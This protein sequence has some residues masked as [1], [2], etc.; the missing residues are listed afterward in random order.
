MRSPYDRYR[1]DGD[2]TAISE[3]AKRGERIFFSDKRGSCAQCHGGWNFSGSL[4]FAGDTSARAAFFNTGL[5]NV[6]GRYSYP[7]PNTG[8][9][10]VSGRLADVGKFRPPTLRNIAVTAPYM[11]DGS[12]STLEDVIDHYAAGGRTI[13]DGPFAG[14]GRDNR[15]K[16]PHVHGFA[17]TSSERRDLIAFLETLTDTAFLH[18]PALSNPWK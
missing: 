14:V 2:S 16:S 10:R 5:Y 7:Q 4:R 8:L 1:Y 13:T 12:I 18:N 17:I 9:Y 11:H 6:A 3:T 15:N